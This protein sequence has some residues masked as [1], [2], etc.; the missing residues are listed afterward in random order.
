[1]KKL[2]TLFCAILL[3]GTFA[4]AA[5]WWARSFVTLTT[6]NALYNY[7]ILTDRTWTVDG[8]WMDN[9]AFAN[10]DFD[11][12]SSLVLNGGYGHGGYNGSD[13]LDE[14][15]FVLYYRA[16]S[17]TGTPGTWSSIP[18]NNFYFSKG[19]VDV[20]YNNV[21]AE[22]DVLALVSNA[23]GSYY[24]EVILTKTN[25]WNALKTP[26]FTT[27]NSGTSSFTLDTSSTGYKANFTISITSDVP[28]LADSEVNISTRSGIINATFNGEKHVEL[29]TLNG[30][31]I[32]STNADNEFT[33]A[34]NNGVYLLK[35]NGIAHKVLVY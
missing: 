2:I 5:H 33:Q 31:L 27:A 16:Y 34:V 20:I 3:A 8:E 12:V 7:G 4:S 17:T 21:A 32:R 14:S 1:M 26:N 35:I 19:S 23:P 22:V 29:F 11:T 6:N 25:Y 18:L 30:Q 24:L 9:V 15:S 28:Q 10:Y 13:Y